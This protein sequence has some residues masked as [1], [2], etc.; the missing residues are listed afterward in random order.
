[1]GNSQQYR[2]HFTVYVKLVT[3]FDLWNEQIFT[4]MG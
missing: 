4:I 1:M 3:E 2:D